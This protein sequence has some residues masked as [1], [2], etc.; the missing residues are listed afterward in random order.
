MELDLLQVFSGFVA[1]L[2]VGVAAV[3]L[4]NKLR[5]GSASPSGVKQEFDDYKSQV[6]SH[7]EETSKKFQDMTEQYQDLYKHLSTGAVTLCRPDSVAAGLVESSVTD[8]TPKLEADIGSEEKKVIETEGEKSSS[9]VSNNSSEGHEGVNKGEAKVEKDL[10]DLNK[11]PASSDN[12]T[13]NR[14]SSEA[15]SKKSTDT[16]NKD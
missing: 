16:A 5:S 4:F 7:F 6:E 2:I 1:G 14:D 8:G 15:Q 13:E 9:T 3:L 11:S 10:E 12:D